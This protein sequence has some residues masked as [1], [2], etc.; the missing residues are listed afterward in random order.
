MTLRQF[1]NGARYGS[2]EGPAIVI[3]WENRA[4]TYKRMPAR[5]VTRLEQWRHRGNAEAA[6]PAGQALQ[7]ADYRTGITYGTASQ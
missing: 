3:D 2:L 6:D 5:L 7:G 1:L 4:V